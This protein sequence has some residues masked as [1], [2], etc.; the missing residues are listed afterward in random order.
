VFYT[1]DH[2]ISNQIALQ[3][4][5][6]KAL[7]YRY[8]YSK[9][10]YNAITGYDHYTTDKTAMETHSHYSSDDGYLI[11]RTVNTLGPT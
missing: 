6:S 3:V 10:D 2:N 7:H 8:H 5:H 9:P 11:I 1:T 4:S